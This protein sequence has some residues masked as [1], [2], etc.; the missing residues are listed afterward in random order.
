[1]NLKESLEKLQNWP[2]SK[3][4]IVLWTIVGV[5]AVIMG[6]FWVKDAINSFSKIGDIGKSINLPSMDL[7]SMDILSTSSSGNQPIITQAPAAEPALSE[8]EGW[9][10][11]TNNDYGIGFEFK[12]PSDVN[13]DFAHEVG[14]RGIL[15][16]YDTSGAIIKYNPNIDDDGVNPDITIYKSHGTATI[17]NVKISGQDGRIIS[18]SDGTSHFVVTFPEPLKFSVTGGTYSYLVVGAA[19]IPTKYINQMISTFKFINK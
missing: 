10:T 8:V 17:T 2:D 12:Y 15:F 6:S 5:L 11:Y 18:Y 14:L 3:K 19:D 1:M 4:K 13:V 9:K 7:P 16:A